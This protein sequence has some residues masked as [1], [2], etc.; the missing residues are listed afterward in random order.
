MSSP[1]WP[2]LPLTAL[3]R[4]FAQ[5]LQQ[6]QPSDD[7]RH[8]LLAA[9]ASHQFGRGHACLDLELLAQDG[10]QAL[11]WEVAQA[12][13]LPADLAHAAATM[14][15]VA[16]DASPLVR[17]RPRLYLRR[18]WSAEQR[19]RAAIDARL[20]QRCDPPENLSAL[21][22]ALF[23]PVSAPGEGPDWQKVACALAARARLTL[24]SGG[25]GTGKTTIVARLLALLQTGAPGRAWRVALAAPTGKAAARLGTSI[26]AALDRLPPGMRPQNLP[27]AVTLHKLLQIRVDQPDAPSPGLAVD[28]VIVD[29]ASMIDL[30]MMARLLD[31]VPLT[32]SLILL[33]DRDQLASVEAGAVLAQLCDGA[34]QGR[35]TPQTL[36]WVQT[37]AGCDLAAWAGNGG[38]LAQQ[39]VM[40]RTSRRFGDDSAIGMWARAV[41]AGDVAHVKRLWQAAP[42]HNDAQPYG[43]DRLNC[44][45]PQDARLGGLFRAG[46]AHWLDHLQTMG[47][48]PATDAQAAQALQAYAKYQVL[49]VVR[50]GPWGVASLN[51]RI[52]HALGFAD[53]DWFAGR[54]VM[55]T[56]NDYHLGL[57]NGD[58]GL[59]LPH[60]GGLGVAFADGQG[61]VRWVRPSRLDGVESVFAMTVHKSQGSE[62]DHV[63]LVLPDQPVAVLTRELLYTGITRS[64]TRLTL[65][66]PDVPVLWRAVDAKVLRSG[67]L[68]ALAGQV[69]AA[70]RVDDT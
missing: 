56:R 2:H 11:G 14:P 29:E 28:L 44:S 23:P 57:M 37:V 34:E 24:I 26:T 51:R 16:G 9:L 39:T 20:Q 46:W 15:W 50:E 30:D 5:Y 27:K 40:L 43:V 67:G 22:S 47:N 59:C 63:C 55:I 58:V 21:L 66:V 52:A 68:S 35:Y 64:R 19:I 54:P 45:A 49:C 65:V 53:E 36:A 8:A 12:A 31:A 7:P 38:A 1:L 25:P 17:E 10:A 32:T 48:T 60:A 18:N 4:A 33:G 41:N 42:V 62:F 69:F 70:G 6:A 61:A 3:D 13:M